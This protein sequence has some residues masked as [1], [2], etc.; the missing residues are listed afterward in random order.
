MNRTYHIDESDR[1]APPAIFLGSWLLI[2]LV[3]AC[4]LVGAYHVGGAT[5]RWVLGEPDAAPV[6]TAPSTEMRQP[7]PSAAPWLPRTDRMPSIQY[8]S[9]HHVVVRVRQVVD[10]D[11]V[12]CTIGVDALLRRASIA[13]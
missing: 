1:P 8:V 3:A 6:P 11:E 9:D 4:A 12:M 10:G 2:L 7:E 5:I 13:C